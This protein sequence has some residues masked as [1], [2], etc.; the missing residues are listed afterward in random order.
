MEVPILVCGCGMRI[1]APG[2]KPGRVGRCPSC[3]G[4]LEVPAPSAGEPEPLPEIGLADAPRMLRPPRETALQP[5]RV[6]KKRR[7]SRPDR[8]AAGKAMPMADGLLPLLSQPEK[9]WLVSFLYPLRG[10]ESLAMAG[11]MGCLFWIFGVMVT[12]YC[13]QVMNDSSSMGGALLG[14]LFVILAVVPVVILL[15]MIVA[16]WLQYLGRILVTSAQGDVAPPRMPD[17][18]FDGFLNGLSPWFIWMVLG[19]ALPLA[20]AIWLAGP[21]GPGGVPLWAV[22]VLAAAALP[23]ILAALM[24]SFLHDDTFAAMP[25][26]VLLALVRLGPAFVMLCGLI[27]VAAGGL[28]GAAALAV[29]IRPRAYWTY[30]LFALPCCVAFLWIQMV[31][32]RL[33]GIY[34]FHRKAGLKWQATNLR[35]GIAWKL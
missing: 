29:W 26:G 28:G 34:Y 5:P 22:A 3:G 12:E 25:W 13:L 24:L 20:P 17:R 31:V 6:K 7:S 11:S 19:L 35:W 16:Y 27:A 15:P 1:R 21:S 9:G 33:L 14:L 10:A 32:M 23:W 4:R 30:I 2:A 18:N 8:S